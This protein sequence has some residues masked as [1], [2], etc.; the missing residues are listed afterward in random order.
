MRVRKTDGLVIVRDFVSFEDAAA[1]L[2]LLA[3]VAAG[4]ANGL[5]A[6]THAVESGRHRVS[7]YRE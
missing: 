5:K 7:K 1:L 3:N 2:V 4:V 6:T